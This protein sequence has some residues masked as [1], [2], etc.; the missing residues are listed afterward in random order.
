M[1][2]GMEI[3]TSFQPEFKSPEY[4]SAQISDLRLRLG[5]SR[6]DFARA[7]D[8]SLDLIFSWENGSTK[9]TI[10]QRSYMMRLAQHAD[11]YSEKTALRPAL[12]CA[13]R[14]RKIGQI[15]TDDVTLG[16]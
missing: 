3:N 4:S 10:G 9:P 2:S 13:L 6:A 14:D 8:V 15:H 1:K 7:F 5:Q 11:E 12:E 16:S